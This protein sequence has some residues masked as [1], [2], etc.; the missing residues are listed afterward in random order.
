MPINFTDPATGWSGVCVTDGSN[1]RPAAG[2]LVLQNVMHDGHNFARDIRPIGIRLK[3]EQVTPRNTVASI[4]SVFLPLSDPPFTVGAI[5]TLVPSPTRFPL[6]PF[7]LFNYLREADET[8]Q[9]S[10]FFVDAR[11]GNYIGY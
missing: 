6:P 8:L 1:R 11:S 3:L 2:G 10:T 7:S 5:Q 9:F 4:T